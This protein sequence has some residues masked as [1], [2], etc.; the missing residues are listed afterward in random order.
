MLL[1]DS[2][3]RSNYNGLQITAASRPWNH[4][5]FHGFYTLSKTMTS[6]QLQNNTTQGLAQDFNNLS[7]EKGRADFDRRNNFVTSFIW[8]MDY[9]GHMN[10]VVRG[11][12]NGWTLSAIVSL[13]SG[14]PFTITSITQP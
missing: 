13:R 6:V 7:L 4:V 1:I 2:D 9:F 14:L 3:Q 12:M 8:Q 5:S 11:V 10:P